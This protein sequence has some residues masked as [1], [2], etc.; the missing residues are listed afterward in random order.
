MRTIISYLNNLLFPLIPES[1]G[2]GIKRY[3][4]RLAGVTV[5]HNVKISS[6]VKIYGAGELSIGDNTWIGYDVMIVASSKV[7]I[8]SNVDIAPRV[9]IGT[10]S[11][12]VDSRSER[13]AAKDISL[14][15]RI[16]DGCWICANSSILP[17][18]TVP[19]KC[20]VAAGSVVT[21][22]FREENILIGGVPAHKIK[23]YD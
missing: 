1:K 20:V 22:G 23:T 19:K 3:M 17:G 7:E 2:F 11:H 9:Y 13:M 10:G 6:S 15:V 14:D 18:V 8:G 21:S 4:L 16:G 5:G 12:E